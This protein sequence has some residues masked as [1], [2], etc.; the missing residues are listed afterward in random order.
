M[1]TKSMND[2]AVLLV[3]PNDT[4]RWVHASNEKL[5]GAK[6]NGVRPLRIYLFNPTPLLEES[7]RIAVDPK[8]GRVSVHIG[9]DLSD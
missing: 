2:R 4:E 1:E 9:G 8:V 3:Y 5:R 7:A 6:L